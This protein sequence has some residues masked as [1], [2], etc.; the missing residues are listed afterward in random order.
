[1]VNPTH[2]LLFLTFLTTVPAAATPE[3]WMILLEDPPAATIWAQAQAQHA[4]DPAAARTAA[5]AAVIDHLRRIETAQMELMAELADKAEDTRVLFRV[6]RVLNGIAVLAPAERVEDILALPG[7]L[8]VRPVVP[9]HLTNS[10]SVPFL[11]TTTLWDGGGLAAT[12]TGVTIG[13]IDSGIDYLHTTFGGLGLA[14]DYA[15]NDPTTLADGF[16]PS[17]KIVGG[18]D[19][20]GD[21]YNASDPANN[22]PMPDLDPM[23]CSGHGTHVAGIAAGF[24][25]NGDGSTYLGAY[26]PGIDFNAFGIGPGVAP[27]ASLYALKVFGCNGDTAVVELALEWAVDPDGNGD[28]SDHLDVVNLSLASPIGDRDD[29]TSLAADNA[30]LAGVMVVAAAGNDGAQHFL[31]G[32]PATADRVLAVAATW[33]PDDT[34]LA[35]AVRVN[36]PPGIAGS[37]QAGGANFGP[38]ILAPLNGNAVLASPPD[39]CT[40]LINSA[41]EIDGNIA[42]IERSADCT[43]VTQVRNAQEAGTTGASA[44]V[45]VNDRPGL[46]GVFNDGTGGDITIPV[47]LIRQ[48]AGEEIQDQLP[49]VVDLTLTPSML[50][51]VFALFS[52][53]GPRLSADQPALKPDI[54]A[55]GVAIT[56]ARRGDSIDGG[57]L[58]SNETGTSMASPHAAGAAALLHQIHP[59]WTPQQIKALLMN[60]AGDVYFDPEFTPPVLTP[61]HLGAGRLRLGQASQ[62]EVIAFNSSSPGQVGISFGAL[63]V[64]TNTT[65][66]RTVRFENLGATP[67]VYSLSIR[68][69]SDVP[70]VT[71]TLIGNPQ[72]TVPAGGSATVPFLLSVTQAELRHSHD[73]TLEESTFGFSRHWLSEEAG[74]LLATPISGT[75]TTV[76]RIP[77]YAAIRPASSMSAS[78][79]ILGI[80]PGATGSTTLDLTGLGV[81]TGAEPPLDVVSLVSAFELQQVGGGGPEDPALVGVTTDFPASPGGLLDSQVY[82]GVA[83]ADPWS[84]LHEVAI[85]IFID[86]DKDG[87]ADFLLTQSDEGTFNFGFITDAFVGVLHDLNSPS[88]TLQ[89]PIN[90][91]SPADG[92]TAPF[93]TD[94]A[95]LS[96]R[97]AD[98][99]LVPGDSTF[100][101]SVRIRPKVR[102]GDIA[103][104]DVGPSSLT[105]QHIPTPL[106]GTQ[107]V[108]APPQAGALPGTILRY[109]PALPGLTFTGGQPGPPTYP[110]QGGAA[111]PI[112]FDQ[113][114]IAASNSLGLLLLH[115]HNTLGQRT[116]VIFL[117]DLGP[118]FSDNFET[119]NTS[120][121]SFVEP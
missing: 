12:G 47:L 75:E 60:S 99:G 50:D 117:L 72:V 92:D 13:I 45:L 93:F 105:V 91:I 64:A 66:V 61:V 41:A 5:T 97:T 76:L 62:T 37:H 69:L 34:F 3:Q 40:P 82:F 26:G 106:L 38:N 14:A 121:W 29:P 109:N 51:D 55:P 27:G 16:F 39:A 21:E 20:V 54:A 84:T 23:D 53:R 24:G 9:K 107:R 86:T 68:T 56:S 100:D 71:A 43:Y 36:S 46:E 87:T 2:I 74:H 22:V 48:I 49:G 1:M 101:Y 79:V 78:S 42:V 32:S 104:T 33:D 70:G 110:D 112:E 59:T 58:G 67:A 6:Q 95:L 98:L 18:H 11:G 28:F 44:V 77:F 102:L 88:T 30:V 7:V 114:A 103:T 8:T 17:V 108:A 4:G 89:E 19:F 120:A 85:E 15:T 116:E 65:V 111:V 63:V 52:S 80:G 118:I 57:M 10:T 31:V 94:V 115:H 90:N 96:V 73:P 83:A 113:P 81:D 25:T 35:R 119:G